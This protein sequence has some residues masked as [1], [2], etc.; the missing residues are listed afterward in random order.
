[1]LRENALYGVAAD[2]KAEVSKSVSIGSTYEVPEVRVSCRWAVG[3]QCKKCGAPLEDGS[4]SPPRVAPPSAAANG[5][6][7]GQPLMRLRAR[8][9]VVSVTA[10]ADGVWRDGKIIVMSHDASFPDRCVK[11]NQPAAGYRLKRKLTWHPSGWYATHSHQRPRL[12]DRG[13]L[14]SEESAGP[15][16]ALRDASQAPPMAHWARPRTSSVGDHWLRRSD[17]Q[18][19]RDRVIGVIGGIVLLILG[20]NVLSAS[21]IDERFA[22]IR[23]A[24]RNFLES[25]PPFH[26]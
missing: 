23:G 6:R 21:S 9:A 17:R 14:R 4:F 19:E 12:C 3:G 22:R 26:R 20:T 16:W 1:M 2:V 25:L 5:G 24:H 7:R 13:E 18:P 8:R 15:R 10:Q 11:C